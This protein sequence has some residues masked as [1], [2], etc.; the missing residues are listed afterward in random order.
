MK[1]KTMSMKQKIDFLTHIRRIKIF[2][3]IK[4]YKKGKLI[5][6]M[7]RARFL[8]LVIL[9]LILLGISLYLNYRFIY[10]LIATHSW[11]F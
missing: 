8:K 6:V 11:G 1:W 2:K 9:A 7:P 5:A 3:E 10:R 4:I